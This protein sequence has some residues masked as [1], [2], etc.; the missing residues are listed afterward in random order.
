M[1][2][3]LHFVIYGS[4]LL[5]ILLS[6][7]PS[8]IPA[9]DDQVI[10]FLLQLIHLYYNMIVCIFFIE[11]TI[12]YLP[13]LLSIMKFPQVLFLHYLLP[14]PCLQCLSVFISLM[15]HLMWQAAQWLQCFRQT[16]QWCHSDAD[17]WDWHS[18][19]TVSMNTVCYSM[20]VVITCWLS[21]ILQVPQVE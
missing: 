14:L 4:Y 11:V 19:K 15:V 12:I 16:N 3:L 21:G 8:R 7:L 2:L 17:W 20:Y 10:F 5:L 1:F 9:S 6:S 13:L 18:L